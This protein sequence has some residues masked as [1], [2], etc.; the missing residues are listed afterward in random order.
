[1]PRGKNPISLANLHRVGPH[2]ASR[3]WS[4]KAALDRAIAQDSGKRL[5]EAA[6]MLL[7][8]AAQGEP[9]AIRELADRLDGKSRESVTIDAQPKSA[10]DLSDAELLAIAAER[11]RRA[12]APQISA[13]EPDPDDRVPDA[14]LPAGTASLQDRKRAGGG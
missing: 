8:N 10:A 1:M 14:V 3:Y 12:T 6:E 11:S 4:F 5:R 9:W 7:T 2:A 13:P